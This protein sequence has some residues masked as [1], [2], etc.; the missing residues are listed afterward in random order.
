VAG[1]GSVPRT[2]S[3]EVDRLATLVE[4][5]QTGGCFPPAASLTRTVSKTAGTSVSAIELHPTG[6]GVTIEGREDTID[7]DPTSNF[8]LTGGAGADERALAGYQVVT[9]PL[10]PRTSEGSVARRATCPAERPPMATV[11][12]MSTVLVIRTLTAP[13]RRR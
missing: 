12:S 3:G 5:P 7:G 2:A 4:G 8:T 13:R 6:R 9:A 10:R 11:L 1:R